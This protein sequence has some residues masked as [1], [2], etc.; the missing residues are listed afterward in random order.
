MNI[1]NISRGEHRNASVE[2]Y[3][4]GGLGGEVL[5]SD[6]YIA[7]INKWRAPLRLLDEVA[8]EMRLL[9]KVQPLNASF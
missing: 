2:G 5:N 8:E 3:L 4:G 6:T 9:G 7:T 1:L